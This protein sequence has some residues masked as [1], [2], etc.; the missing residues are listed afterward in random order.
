MK[1]NEPKE[2]D[3]LESLK[4]ELEQLEPET[5][6]RPRRVLVV[7]GS[8]M[9]GSDAVADFKKR[10][11]EVQAPNPDELD[12]TKAHDI[13]KVRI[14]DYGNLDWIVNCAAYTAVD[15]AE[16]EFFQANAVNGVGPGALAVVCEK[17]DWRF[18]HISTDFVFDG[19]SD[20]P[21]TE[22]YATSPICK[23]GVT[24]LMGER[25]AL[26]MHP[27]SVIA[28]TAWLYGPNGKSFPRTIIKAWMDGKDLKV[29]GDQTGSPTYTADL[30]RVMGDL[31]QNDVEG[32]VYHAAGPDAM[33]WLEF[34]NH[35]LEIYRDSVLGELRPID[36]EPV[37]T[38]DWPTPA[39]R[40]Q[41]SV[42]NCD[43]LLAQGIPPMRSTP[44]AL[45]DFCKR[46]PRIL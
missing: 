6:A 18:L 35:A 38:A 42:L 7:G 44:S 31:I 11:W 26:M 14:R 30:A 29:V 33:T 3:E 25:N 23:Y 10:G 16:E 39:K 9:L 27:R 1:S 8:G 15:K 2:N 24:K 4:T 34:A 37:T 19:R 17:N 40:P 41:F 46:L 20:K 13:E 36:I 28:R 45:L 12:L 21:Y 43:K 5:P 32:G 22:Q